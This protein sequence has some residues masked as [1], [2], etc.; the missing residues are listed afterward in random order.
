MPIPLSLTAYNI[1]DIES[2]RN[3]CLSKSGVT[4]MFPFDDRVLVFKVMG[5][6]FALTDVPS[7]ESI[8]LKCDPEKALILREMHA[9][10][11]PGY[12]MNK[13]HWNTVLMDG[14]VPDHLVYQWIDDAY[15]LVVRKLPR[16]MR[17]QLAGEYE[18][19]NTLPST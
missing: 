10:V 14:S 5:K 8:N 11:T 15:R 1:M 2:F 6:M 18:F 13:Q 4:E 19:R 17:D 7:F 3:Y 9:G 16:T 12:H